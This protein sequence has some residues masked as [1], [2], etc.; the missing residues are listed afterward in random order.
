M[1]NDIRITVCV[2][3]FG[4]PQR[5]QRLIRLLEHQTINNF[6]VLLVGDNCPQFAQYL[7]SKEWEELVQREIQKGN[8]WYGVNFPFHYGGWGYAARNWMAYVAQ[9]QYLIF[10]D[11]DDFVYHN[12]LAHYLSEIEGT[13]LDFVFYDSYLYQQ[14]KVL[15]V[16]LQPSK[17]GHSDIIIK[18]D[19][20]RTLSPQDNQYG[21]DWRMIQQMMRKT[22]FYKKAK[23]DM[24]TYNIMGSDHGREDGI[25]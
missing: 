23:S 15:N 9:G 19:F 4:R 1:S 20:F 11:N 14:D 12:H 16:Q 5:T 24:C 7:E 17:I 8:E 2:P 22:R 10:I 13:N 6:E 18:T 21:H 3:V 25:D